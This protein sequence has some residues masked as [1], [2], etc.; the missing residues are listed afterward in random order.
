MGAKERQLKPYLNFYHSHGIDTLS[1]AVGPNHVLF[2]KTA[3]SHMMKVLEVARDPHKNGKDELDHLIFHHFSVGGFLYGQMLRALAEDPSGQHATLRSKVRA[4]IFDSPP[5]FGGIAKGVSRSIGIGPPISHAVEL[6]LRAYLKATENTSGVCH[7]AASEAFHDNHITAPS[8]WYYSRSDPV[9][10]WEDCE[11]VIS[12]WRA[13]GT[14]VEQCV[15][16]DT[17]HIQHGRHD[18]ERY[19]G[20]LKSF[21]ANADIPLS[22]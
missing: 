14:K 8:L 1:F 20:T 22:S 12:K 17:P 18:P 11:T 10:A 7:R 3:M 15:W 19:F 13:K 21:L 9:A 6:G 16:E 5:D 2:P 4:Q